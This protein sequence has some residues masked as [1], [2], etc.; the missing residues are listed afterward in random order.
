MK[1][2]DPSHRVVSSTPPSQALIEHSLE[3]PLSTLA[4]KDLLIC[5]PGTSL[6]QPLAA[7]HQRGV[8][9]VLVVD[10]AQA[11]VGIL[12]RHDILGRVT[13]PGV[14]LASPIGGVMTSPLHTLTLA[15][16]LQDAA[17]LMARHGL[18]HVPVT[19]GVQ[20]VNI[21]SERDLFAL[22][23][24]SLRQLSSRI[25]AAPDM[26][27]LQVAAADI[28]RLA[29]NLLAQGVQARQLTELIS[30]LNDVLTEQLVNLVALRRGIDM[31]RAC[32]LAF[33]SEGRSEQT[34]A[35]DQDN[36]LVFLS[37]Q[38]DADRPA[39]L[40]FAREVNAGLDACG[41]PLC[42]GNVMASNPDCCLSPAEWRARFAHWLEHGAPEDL[43]N[44]SIYFDL[45]PVAGSRALAAPLRA[46]IIDEPQ[47]VPRFIKQMAD[48][49]LRNGAP[50]NWFGAVRTTSVDGRRML[51]L[52][53]RGAAI[54]V[55][56]AR[57]YAL[58]KGIDQIGTRPRLAAVA[59]AL[60]VEPNEGE[61]WISAF[62]YLQMLRL[63]VQLCREPMPTVGNPNLIDVASLNDIERRMLRESLRVARSLQQRIELDYRR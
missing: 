50:L 63:Q 61:A 44:A 10:P 45:R 21:V 43:L 2:L 48:N 40:D 14:S 35:T 20:V 24:L 33:G 62:E 58:A 23:R 34:V 27:S 7:M 29:R 3:A 11:P 56:A 42:K 28:R 41:Y 59:Q 60:S 5:A 19:D 36:G 9:S 47:R 53:L 30:H 15:H 8:G 25:R 18:R 49:A 4:R 17:L 1:S 31:A 54:F 55:D 52:K 32:W 12:T 57:L 37:E 16:T 13:L 6:L 38:P 22:Q 51:D 46:M 39:W 26:G